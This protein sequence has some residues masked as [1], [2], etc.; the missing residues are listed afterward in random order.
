[1]AAVIII[2]ESSLSEHFAGCK[3]LNRLDRGVSNPHISLSLVVCEKV[4]RVLL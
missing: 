1:M 2:L 3:T 4:V